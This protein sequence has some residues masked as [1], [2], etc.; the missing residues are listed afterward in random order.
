MGRTLG[1]DR[2]WPSKRFMNVEHCCA[3]MR[4][5]TRRIT[6]LKALRSSVTMLIYAVRDLGAL[7]P[8][9]DRRL[10][11]ALPRRPRASASFQKEKQPTCAP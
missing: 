8:V 5:A 1:R 4:S 11:L 9:N 10:E 3:L 7:Q 6:S 2:M